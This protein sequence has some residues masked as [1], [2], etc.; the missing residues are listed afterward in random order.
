MASLKVLFL[1]AIFA[2]LIFNLQNID[3]TQRCNKKIYYCPNTTISLDSSSVVEVREA[4][5][6]LTR[7]IL[8]SPLLNHLSPKGKDFVAYILRR[9]NTDSPSESLGYYIFSFWS[10]IYLSNPYDYLSLCP[11]ATLLN[12]TVNWATVREPTVM[13]DALRFLSNSGYFLCT[14]VQVNSLSQLGCE[15]VPQPPAM[16]SRCYRFGKAY[17]IEQVLDLFGRSLP[18]SVLDKLYYLYSSTVYSDNVLAAM[19]SLSL[20]PLLRTLMTQ[21]DTSI[22]IETFNMLIFNDVSICCCSKRNRRFNEMCVAHSG[23]LIQNVDTMINNTILFD[24]CATE[25]WTHV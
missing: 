3:A 1:T 8:S 11:I 6:N 17:Q 21:Q 19:Y 18:C 9:L 20:S 15:D 4:Q 22:L 13:V 12:A 24:E 7:N 10:I 5:R 2:L 25:P 16:S 14:M 23:T